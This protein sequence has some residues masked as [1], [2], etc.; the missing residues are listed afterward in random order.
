MNIIICLNFHTEFFAKDLSA[1]ISFISKSN[2]T[3]G[4]NKTAD[5]LMKKVIA[6]L[7]KKFNNKVK[8]RLIGSRAYET[9]IDNDTPVDIY[10]DLRKFISQPFIYEQNPMNNKLSCLLTS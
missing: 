1:R 10:L 8:C 2:S 9:A 6:L 3:F 5:L 4:K 7:D